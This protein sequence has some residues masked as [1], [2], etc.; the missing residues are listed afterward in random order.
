MNKPDLSIIVVN[1]QSWTYL[2]DCLE[3]FKNY[4]PDLKY[5]I[6]VVDNDSNDGYFDNFKSKHPEIN[7]IVNTGNHGFSNGCNL[8]AS[9]AQADTLL[10]LNPDT[11]LNETN[12]IDAMYQYLQ[13][14][15]EDVGIVS[16]RNVTPNGIGKEDRFLSPWFLFG[17][18]RSIHNLLNKDKLAKKFSDEKDIW[19]PG[20]VTG[21]VVMISN[22][23]I[24]KING[25]NG[26]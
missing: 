7:L 18:I 12:S 23:L 5:E 11:E 10:F 25:W 6:I 3:S 22:K 15:H 19:F 4:P 13:K 14:N 21:S 24:K 20:W 26:E 8:G 9:K 1:Y 2:E 16:C 17:Y